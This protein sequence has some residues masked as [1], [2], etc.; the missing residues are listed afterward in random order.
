MKTS[1]LTGDKLDYWV[2]KAQGWVHRVTTEHMA[3]RGFDEPFYW[4]IP[5]KGFCSQYH[6]SANWQQCG[7]LIEKF[8]IELVYHPR[9]SGFRSRSGISGPF[10][11]GST[12]QEAICRAVVASVY[13][14]E[15]NDEQANQPIR[16]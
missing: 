8:D 11:H 2:A 6:P 15:V 12:P 10:F 16:R 7:E 14:E 3:K 1:E 5:S 4:R 13:G 9:S